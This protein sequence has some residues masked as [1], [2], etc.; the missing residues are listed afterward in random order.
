MHRPWYSA[1]DTKL[2]IAA[3]AQKGCAAVQRNLK[4]TKK[5][6][7]TFWSSPVGSTESCTRG[8]I[9]PHVSVQAGGQPAGKRTCRES[10]GTPGGHQVDHKPGIFL[11][12]NNGNHSFGLHLAQHSYQVK[13][14]DPSPLLRAGEATPEALGPLLGSQYKTCSYWNKSREGSQS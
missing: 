11:Y 5:W 4:R 7:E 10:P 6:H 9:K 8:G 3:D 2:E 1:A 12:R 13:G 14:R